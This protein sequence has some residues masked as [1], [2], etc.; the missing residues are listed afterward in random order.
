MIPEYFRPRYSNL[1]INPVSSVEFNRTIPLLVL[2]MAVSP[3]V[4]SIEERAQWSIC[5]R[6][7]AP[8]VTHTLAK[9]PV[10]PDTVCLLLA[11]TGKSPEGETYFLVYEVVVVGVGM[12]YKAKLRVKYLEDGVVQEVAPKNLLPKGVETTAPLAMPAPGF[13]EIGTEWEGGVSPSDSER[14]DEQ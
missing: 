7:D 8:P 3:R 6:F 10:Q 9:N 5:G 2:R 11:G 1:S 13:G 12:K 4:L 14:D